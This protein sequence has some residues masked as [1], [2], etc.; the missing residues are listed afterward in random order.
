MPRKTEPHPEQAKRVES[1]RMAGQHWRA[2]SRL[3]RGGDGGTVET[4]VAD[5][6]EPALTRLA[7]APGPIEIML[8]P[9]AHALHYLPK[10]PAGHVEE[11]LE[12][13]D[14]VRRDD[15]CDPRQ[16]AHRARPRHT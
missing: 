11:A 9:R 12:A 10:I 16:E 13:E 4:F 2:S 6:H 5:H 7:Q 1:R 3:D 15:L 8:H 14:V